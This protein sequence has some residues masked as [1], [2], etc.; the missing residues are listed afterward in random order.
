MSDGGDEGG[1]HE[2]REAA[3]SPL[4]RAR[5]AD[6]PQ[7][8]SRTVTIAIGAAALAFLALVVL[9]R[10]HRP[11]AT[12]SAPPAAE[13]YASG[14]SPAEKLDKAMAELETLPSAQNEGVAKILAALEGVGRSTVGFKLPDGREAP[15]LPVDAPRVVRFGVVLVKYRGAQL[16][17][18]SA[19]SREAALERAKTLLTIARDDFGAAVKS[20]D[21]GSFVDIGTIKRGVLEPGT[22]YVLFTLPIG[23]TSEVLDTPRGFWIVRRLK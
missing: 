13:T 16:A 6:K 23:W 1:E 12:A 15:P 8:T 7:Q 4:S 20:G 11:P 5:S 18:E 3:P 10:P 9:R 21:S 14:A 22:E 2:E 19:P 17:P